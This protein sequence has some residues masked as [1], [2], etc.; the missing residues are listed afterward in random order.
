[1]LNRVLANAAQKEADFFGKEPLRPPARKGISLLHSRAP[2]DTTIIRPSEIIK[3]FISGVL[4]L[5]TGKGTE[6]YRTGQTLAEMP[7]VKAAA[8]L[9]KAVGKSASVIAGISALSGVIKPKPEMT[10]LSMSFRDVNKRIPEL[11]DA[12][13][14]YRDGKITQAEYFA[15]VDEL[16]PVVPYERV[17]ALATPSEAV[18]ALSI[19]KRKG[20]AQR[21]VLRPKETILSRLDIPA[22]SQRGVWVTSQ[23][24]LKPPEGEPKTIYTPT[25]VLEGPTI[26]LPGTKAAGKVARGE[27]SKTSFATIRGQY[28]PTSDDEAIDLALKAIQ[29]KEYVQIGYDPERR[30]FFYD[31]RTMEPIIGTE[32]GIIQIGPLVLGKR[33]IYGRPEDFEDLK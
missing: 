18:S 31:R 22:Y 13:K 12:A 3:P 30:G 2:K 6:A 7:S 32:G 25:M 16:K 17:P 24:R 26:M 15:I 9:P 11:Q 10:R 28:K 20:F 21:N 8:A 29:D 23:H 1:M 27:E 14:A 5:E 19:D 4:G 33:P